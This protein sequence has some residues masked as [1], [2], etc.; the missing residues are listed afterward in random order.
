[1]SDTGGFS[2]FSVVLLGS[3]GVLIYSA[4][5]G[6]SPITVVQNALQGKRMQPTDVV[7]SL[8][9]SPGATTSGGAVNIPPGKKL[10]WVKAPSGGVPSAGPGAANTTG[11]GWDPNAN[12]PPPIGV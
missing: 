10:K 6:Y 5:K 7:Y 3:G 11:T 12:N 2:L 9:L 8:G 4:V 1:M